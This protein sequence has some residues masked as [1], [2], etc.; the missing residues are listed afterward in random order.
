[1]QD[2]NLHGSDKS[3]FGGVGNAEEQET[4]IDEAVEE[5]RVKL[6]KDGKWYADYVRIRMKA[7][8]L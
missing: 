7:I 4:I 8:K 2:P 1:M 6:H 5:L 3:E